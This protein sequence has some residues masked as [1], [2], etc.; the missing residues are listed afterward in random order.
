MSYSQIV[1][2]QIAVS[3]LLINQYHKLGMNEQQLVIL[4]H[5]Y[6]SKINGVHFPTP[7]EISENMTITT[8][9][10]SRHL[11]NLIQLGYLQ[12]EEDETSGKLKEM[13]SLE[14][15]WEKIYKEPE[16]IEN[17]EEAQIGEMFRR[18]EQEFGRP[19]SPFEIERINSW[20]DEEKYSIELIYAA[21]RE[22]VLMSK[23]NFNYI[24]RILIDWVK[25][26][27]RSLA[28]A[29]ETSKSFHEH[30]NTESKPSQNKPNRKKLYYN[31][32]D[33]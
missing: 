31:W 5:I 19:L 22:A 8:E 14:S 20:I 11:R 32:L 26:G 27:V 10:C 21:L 17:K 24:D 12:I 6:I 2:D 3:K 29:K 16:K 9:E 4:L 13:Y 30:K 1:S 18:F 28:Q 15:L 23:L 7:E 33:E 25:K